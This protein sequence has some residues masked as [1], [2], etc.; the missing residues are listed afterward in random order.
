M[1]KVARRTFT[2]EG[3][4]QVVLAAPSGQSSLAELSKKCEVFSVMI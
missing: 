2:P 3:K 4:T 1:G